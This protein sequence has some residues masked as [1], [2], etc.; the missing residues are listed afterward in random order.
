MVPGARL[1][2]LQGQGVMENE[3]ASAPTERPS[4]APCWESAQLQGQL[5]P[6]PRW[7][8]TIE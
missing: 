4:A 3:A 2:T 1:V 8:M 5:L 7:V 6:G